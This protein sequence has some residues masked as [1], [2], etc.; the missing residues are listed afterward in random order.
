MASA[1]DQEEQVRNRAATM[2]A[3]RYRGKRARAQLFLLKGQRELERAQAR[4]G[5]LEKRSARRS[6]VRGQRQV[7][8]WQ[9]R[10]ARI[11][12]SHF[13]YSKSAPLV[14]VWHDACSRDRAAAL[15]RRRHRVRE[16]L[17]ARA[18]RASHRRALGRR[19]AARSVCT[20][21]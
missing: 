5:W 7:V 20:S 3:G 11:E 21:P 9:R 13:V 17:T 18:T 15:A 10:Y 12:D 1:T 8:L 19:A 6:Y 14:K 2:I 4:A 16:A